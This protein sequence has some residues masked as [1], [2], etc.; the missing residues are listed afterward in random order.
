MSTPILC[1]VMGV[2]GVGKT[3]V[4]IALAERLAIP[5]ADADDLHPPA[6]VAKMATGTPLDDADRWPWLA[7]VGDELAAAGAAGTGLVMACSALK[8]AYRDAI[9]AQAPGAFF[10]H[11]TASEQTLAEHLATRQGHFMPPSLLPSQLATLEPLQPDEVGAEVDTGAPFDQVVARA[12]A[13]V[14]G[15]AG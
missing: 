13:V 4:G 1:V 3:T 9:R 7:A 14:A 6:N 8:R 12:A 2:S 15:V 5:F 10:L 11:L